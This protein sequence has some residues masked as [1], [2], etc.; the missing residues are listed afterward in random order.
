MARRD[1]RNWLGMSEKIIVIVVT[2]FQL[3]HSGE[4]SVTINLREML[5]CFKTGHPI[6]FCHKV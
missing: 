2:A 4:L 1:C 3:L 5:G 6:F